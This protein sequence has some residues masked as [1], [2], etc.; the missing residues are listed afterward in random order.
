VLHKLSWIDRLVLRLGAWLNR[1]PEQKKKMLQDFDG[2][3]VSQL[4]P[5]IQAFHLFESTQLA[6]QLPHHYKHNI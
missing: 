2:V 3:H 6:S 4:E 5:L 1:D